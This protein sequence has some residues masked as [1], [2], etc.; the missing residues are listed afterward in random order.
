MQDKFQFS[1][2]LLG[3]QQEDQWVRAEAQQFERRGGDPKADLELYVEFG[4]LAVL[5]IALVAG[6]MKSKDF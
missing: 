4:V 6:L 2:A 1:P 5:V 3:L